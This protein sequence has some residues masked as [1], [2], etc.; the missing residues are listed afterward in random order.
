MGATLPP[1][2]DES[3]VTEGESG[4]FWGVVVTE[5]G[6]TD[7]GMVPVGGYHAGAVRCVVGVPTEEVEVVEEAGVI[8]GEEYSGLCVVEAVAVVDVV[9]AVG[10]LCVEVGRSG[11]VTP[12]AGRAGDAGVG[13]GIGGELGLTEGAGCPACETGGEVLV[14][15][16]GTMGVGDVTPLVTGGEFGAVERGLLSV[17]GIGM[18]GVLC[19]RGFVIEDGTGGDPGGVLGLL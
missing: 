6:A 3:G 16:G 11:D 12:P 7:I 19:E 4:G 5:K 10:G 13:V 14:G 9:V 15:G 17:D 1:A 18:L 8:T 2:V